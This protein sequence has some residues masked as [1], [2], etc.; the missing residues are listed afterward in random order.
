L[1]DGVLERDD[2]EQLNYEVV[3]VRVVNVLVRSIAMFLIV[4]SG[5]IA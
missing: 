1:V 4:V 2:D 3:C 5:R